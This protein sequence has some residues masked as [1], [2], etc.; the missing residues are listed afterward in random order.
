MILAWADA[1]AVDISNAEADDLV[2]WLERPEI[3]P[4]RIAGQ[5]ERERPEVRGRADIPMYP[6][7]VNR[8]PIGH[9]RRKLKLI[10]VKIIVLSFRSCKK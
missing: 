8:P 3:E 7:Y 2:A 1:H 5:L 4:V 6:N 9:A 10:Q